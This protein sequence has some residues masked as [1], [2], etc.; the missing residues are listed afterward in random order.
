MPSVNPEILRWAR[1]TAG[2][3]LDD[4][5]ARLDLAAA[6]GVQG[7]ERLAALEAGD[8]QPTRPLLLRMA[9]QY[10]R[11]LLTFYLSA[12]PR[13]GSRGEDFRTLPPEH[14]RR[15]AA[16]VDALIRDVRARQGMV[17]ALLEAEDEAVPLPFV[18]SMTLHDPA[19]AVLAAITRILKLDLD[20]F[21]HGSAGSPRSATKGFAYL[22]ERAEEAGIYVLLI[23]SLGSYRSTIDVEIFRGFALADP[24]APFIVIND[25]DAEA[26]WS[27]TLLH[28]LAHIWLGQTGISGANPASEVERLCN[29]VAGRFLLP[30]HEI[31]KETHLGDAPFD[32]MVARVGEIA[33]QCQ[34][35]GSLVAYKL[36]REGILGPD[37]WNWLRQLLRLQWLKSRKARHSRDR[38]ISGGPNY[39][40]VRRHRLGRRLTDLARRMVVQGALTPSKAATILDMK[41]ANVYNLI[42][43]DA[44]IPP[45]RA[46]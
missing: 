15:D 42:S 28:E 41:P 34:V 38:E 31:A 9:K 35:S 25:Q 21:R 37:Q 43:L 44:T 33:K 6:R 17:R 39:Y 16:L 11:P 13:Q 1:E 30:A 45:G 18:G 7:A 26:A 19:E 22:R 29:D 36:Y 2:L 32:V 14:S 5:A 40:V 23:G 24:V 46:A 10:R 3:T 27:F 8:K 20:R 4:A 12:P